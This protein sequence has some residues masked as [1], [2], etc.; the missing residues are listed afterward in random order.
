MAYS[1]EEK[2][3]KAREI[4]NLLGT[5]AADTDSH[6]IDLVIDWTLAMA[7]KLRKLELE[8][9]EKFSIITGGEH[10]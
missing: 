6:T 8:S 7:K 5:N 9:A 3:Q 10:G 2:K 1:L 4:D